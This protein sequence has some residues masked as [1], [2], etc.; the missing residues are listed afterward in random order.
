VSSVGRGKGPRRSSF[1]GCGDGS[2]D[3]VSQVDAVKS[4]VVLTTGECILSDAFPPAASRLGHR[5]NKNNIFVFDII[6]ELSLAASERHIDG[7]PFR[8]GAWTGVPKCT[9]RMVQGFSV[10]FSGGEAGDNKAQ[11]LRGSDQSSRFLF[12]L[13]RIDGTQEKL[14]GS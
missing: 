3:P 13:F 12:L 9:I 11:R 4:P 2:Y 5:P 1:S 10:S 8:W 7:S 6:R 14:C